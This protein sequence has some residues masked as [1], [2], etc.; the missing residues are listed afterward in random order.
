MQTAQNA[1]KADKLQQML[2][3]M[4]AGMQ[5]CNMPP[6]AGRQVVEIAEQVQKQTA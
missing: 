2:K 6:Q 1:D 4:L 3:P 5:I